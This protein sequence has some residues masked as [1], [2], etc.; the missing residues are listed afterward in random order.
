[1]AL[2]QNRRSKTSSSPCGADL[3]DAMRPDFRWAAGQWLAQSPSAEVGHDDPIV[4]RIGAFLLASAESKEA[5]AAAD[6]ELAAA[7]TL[8]T[9]AT[10]SA[11]L[12]TLAI[13]GTAPAEIC[14]LTQVPPA[15][16]QLWERVFFDVRSR[17]GAPG[18]LAHW[19]IGPEEDAGKRRLADRLRQAVGGGPE[20]AKLLIQESLGTTLERADRIKLQQVRVDLKL[21]EAL[22]IPL[23]TPAQTAKFMQA[24]VALQRLRQEHELETARLDAEERQAER[25]H[26]LAMLRAQTEHLAA[27]TQAMIVGMSDAELLATVARYAP[28][29]P[30]GP[31]ILVFPGSEGAAEPAAGRSDAPQGTDVADPETSTSNVFVAGAPFMVPVAARPPNRPEDPEP[32]PEAR[33]A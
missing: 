24:A 9:D 20:I 29:I 4:G 1:M 7:Q 26:E 21:R 13:A 11:T 28:Q 25:A 10:H 31:Q 16:L 19:V 15:L 12:K 6:P 5:A 33:C 22:G 18:W 14:E 23:Q 27:A 30:A 17:L 32:R 8:Q 2:R 3:L